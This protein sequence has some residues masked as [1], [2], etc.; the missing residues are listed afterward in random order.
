MV[1][2][3]VAGL[4]GPGVARAM[5]QPGD[6]QVPPTAPGRLMP[7]WRAFAARAWRPP[8][9]VGHPGDGQQNA[10]MSARYARIRPALFPSFSS[11]WVNRGE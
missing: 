1:T 3:V 10:R 2:S 4:Y 7:W 6:G 8:M 5:G 9:I 11:S